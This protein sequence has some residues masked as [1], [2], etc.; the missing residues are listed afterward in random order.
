MV[1]FY[2]GVPNHQEVHFDS[3]NNASINL[4]AQIF[5]EDMVLISLGA[6][7]DFNRELLD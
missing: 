5:H 2:V 6:I 1:Y 4:R 7:V 3:A